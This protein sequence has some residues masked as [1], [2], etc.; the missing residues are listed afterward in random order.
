VRRRLV[1]LLVLT[2]S[3][4]LSACGSEE[5]GD[6]SGT[7]A[8]AAEE[9]LAYLDPESALVVAVDLRY[10]EE[11]WE[12][13]RGIAD[14]VLEETRGVVE[15]ENRGDVPEDAE[16]ALT[17]FSKAWNLSFEDARPLLT[18]HLLI[19]MTLGPDPG[20]PPEQT[21]VVYRAEDGD[22]RDVVQKALDNSRLRA[23]PGRDDVVASEEGIAVVGDDTLV[24]AASREDALAAI[25]RAEA[26][27]GFAPELLDAAEQGAGIPDPLLLATATPDIGRAFFDGE[28]VERARAEVP[29]LSAVERIDLALDVSEEGL[30]ARGQV[31]TTAAE[32]TADQLPLGPAGDVEL[33]VA[34]DAI[35][36]GSLDQSRIT[37]FAASVARSLF[38]DSDFVAA[39]EETERELGIRFEDEVLRQFDCPSVSVFEPEGAAA[40]GTAGRFSARSCV[41]DPER[42][43]E[44]LPRLAPRLPRILRALHGLSGEGLMGLLMLAPDAP[45]APGLMLLQVGVQPLGGG[46]PEEQLY[47]VN[48][49][50]ESDTGEEVFAG[51]DRVVFG[52]I[53]DDFVVGSDRQAA[54]DAAALDTEPASEQAASALRVPPGLPVGELF[55]SEEANEV[56]ARLWRS[57]DR[58]LGR[59]QGHASARPH[60]ARRLSSP[61]AVLLEDDPGVVLREGTKSSWE[62]APNRRSG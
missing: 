2:A 37:T 41:R 56:L 42:M 8:E 57:R 47:E 21:T 16:A 53:G 48:G 34:Q 22:L 32:L 24:G 45:L 15:P 12:S 36:G 58:L 51:P 38:A 1:L 26:G 3:V 31:V 19:G 30:A 50:R 4:A 52:M 7:V 18:G 33:P 54:R 40:L 5:E 49:L 9:Q 35:A 62:R 13:L 55:G 11:N 10:E 46:G 44:L 25:E 23:V 17:E 28:D 6:G 43:R 39:V 27:R 20:D 60:A 59:P 29:Y 14:R 61:P